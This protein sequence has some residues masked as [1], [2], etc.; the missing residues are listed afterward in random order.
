MAAGKVSWRDVAP[1]VAAASIGAY[2]LCYAWTAALIGLLPMERVDATIVATSFA[3][4]LF[5]FLIL[6]AFAIR[7]VKRLWGEM[8]V[9][10]AVPA[11]I[12]L[13]LPR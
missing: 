2:A 11:L 5:V 4:L 7:D 9:G 12:L 1:R 6:R 3:F 8:L 10:T 13:V